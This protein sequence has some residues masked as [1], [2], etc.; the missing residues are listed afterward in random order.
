MAVTTKPTSKSAIWGCKAGEG[1]TFA[2]G[3]IISMSVKTSTE[4]EPLLDSN[5]ETAGLS[6]YDQKSEV[7]IEVVAEASV[8]LPEIG[9]DLI[10]DGVTGIVLDVETKWEQ[11]GWK[12]FSVQAT[13]FPNLDVDSGSDAGLGVKKPAPAADKK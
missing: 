6:L 3:K 7:Q 1:D 4:K 8:A 2:S 9:A 12:K 10:V 13:F 5:G 11:K